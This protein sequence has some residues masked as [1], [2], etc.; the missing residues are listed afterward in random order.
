MIAAATSQQ[1]SSL[2]GKTTIYEMGDTN[3][4]AILFLHGFPDT[5]FT[6]RHQL[7]FFAENGYRAIAPVMSGYE[8][9]SQENEDYSY[10]RLADD[11]IVWMDALGIEKAHLVG[12]DFGAIIAFATAAKHE[13]RIA[14]LGSIAVPHMTNFGEVLKTN[15]SQL[16]ETSHVMFFAMTGLA[17]LWIK[18]NDF[19]FVKK[20]WARWSPNLDAQQDIDQ[21]KAM[22]S[23]PK[24]MLH[25][26]KYYKDSLNQHDLESIDL[27]AR[28]TKVPTLVAYGMQ[29]PAIKNDVFDAC[30]QPE[31]FANHMQ[32]Q[33]YS[34][35]AHYP[36]LE[37][38]DQ[39]NQD[40]LGFIH[41]Y[42]D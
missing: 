7:Q 11:P 16:R 3:A 27:I 37:N 33:K 9:S 8:P 32:Y 35:M 13:N 23:K 14:S 5:P 21:I 29:D 38:P 17:N 1:I 42:T 28:Q 40:M 26:L 2:G 15:M 24:T 39:I 41:Q 22:Y 25:A 19:A 12:H 6:W 18:R 36:H 20:A 31:F 10:K 30:M 34:D 4:P